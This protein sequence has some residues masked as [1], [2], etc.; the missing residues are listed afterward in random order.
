MLRSILSKFTDLGASSMLSILSKFT[1][2]S[3]SSMLSKHDGNLLVSL[4]AGEV[5][6]SA[7]FLGPRL[8]VGR[9]GEEQLRQLREPLL[10]GEGQRTLPAVG[11]GGDGVAP[12]VEEKL[13]DVNM[14]LTA[15]L[16]IH[17]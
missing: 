5:E 3:A 1:D 13:H 7:P 15:S 6:R 11:E 4:P 10:G 16:D 8:D 9:A 14:V 2:L 17:V 12:V